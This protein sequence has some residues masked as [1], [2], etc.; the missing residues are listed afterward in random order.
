MAINK[1]V[2]ALGTFGTPVITTVKL[3]D[4]WQ[5]AIDFKDHRGY[6]PLHERP[7]RSKF[8][9]RNRRRY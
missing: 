3:S 6:K 4:V 8:K 9:A 5:A 7:K 2:V 1:R